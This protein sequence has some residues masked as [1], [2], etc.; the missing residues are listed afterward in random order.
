MYSVTS[1]FGN[2]REQ[3]MSAQGELW[4]MPQTIAWFRTRT[5]MA[6]EAISEPRS[7]RALTKE[8]LTSNPGRRVFARAHS[9]ASPNI[10]FEPMPAGQ[11]GGG[12]DALGVLIDAT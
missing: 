9:K 7:A 1:V 3:F 4:T 8:I 6:V 12:Q 11:F 5:E 2:D 10:R